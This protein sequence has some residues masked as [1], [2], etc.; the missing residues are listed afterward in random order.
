MTAT[1]RDAK[2]GGA[3]AK[4]RAVLAGG[5]FWCV[6]AIFK[7]LDGVISV[8]PGYAGGTK[9]NPTYEEVCTG[10]TGHAEAVEILFDPSRISYADLLEVF[11][12]THD[13]TQLNRQGPDV[14]T[15]Y[16]SAVFVL[17][18]RQRR[19]AEEMK[20]RAQD[21][22][23]RPIVTEIAQVGRFWPA[24]DHHHDYFARN[25]DQPYCAAVVAPK[26]AKARAR[27]RHRLAG[28]R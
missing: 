7:D 1:E 14:G 24:E 4:E 19:I 8:R 5:C 6:E 15:Q 10:T 12:T 27:W 13:P 9:E 26:V 18:A 25:P 22:W 11:F 20:A 17:D 2:D 23:D 3:G 21:L 28:R 16:R